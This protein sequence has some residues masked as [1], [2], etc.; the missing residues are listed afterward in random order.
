MYK[1]LFKSALR[2]ILNKKFYTVINGVGLTLGLLTFF[3]VV[4]HVSYEKNYDKFHKKADNIYRLTSATK[5]RTAA[6]VPYRWG[7]QMKEDIAEIENVVSFQNITI[8][9]TVKKGSEIYA[10]HGFLGVDST[11]LDIFDYPVLQGNRNELLR[12]PD[13]MVITPQIAVK[14]FN[15]EN[16]IGKT[17]KVNLWGTDVT[18][19][20]EGIVDCPKNAHLQFKFLIPIDPVK[21]N[22]FAPTAFDS[23]STHFAHSYF[24]MKDGFNQQKVERD[25]KSFLVNHGGNQLADKYTPALQPLT[26]V[27]LKSHGIHFDFQPRG[28][29]QQ[30]Y[31]L[32]AVAVGILIMAI[33][34]FTNIGS[35]QSLSRLKE[36]SV[37]KILGSRKTDLFLQFILESTILVLFSTVIAI[38]L[39]FFFNT[40]LTNFAGVTFLSPESITLPNLLVVL[41]IG[42]LI[43][44]ISGIYPALLTSSF[45]PISILSSR[46]GGK[47]KSGRTGKILV[48]IQFSLAIVLLSA[49][50]IVYKQIQYMVDKDLGFNKEQIII[51]S[52]AREVASNPLKM[53]L[54]KNTI[55][56]FEDVLSATATSSFPGDHEGQW[57]ARY[58]P[59]GMTPDES[60]SL[61]SIYADHDFVKTYD[62]EIVNGRDFNKD[63]SSDSTVTLL[64]EAA[65]ELF[66]NSN[67]LWK[68][69]P[70]D[71]YLES[72]GVRSRVIGVL[73]DFHFQSL[74]QEMNPLVIQ[75]NP[76]NAFS[77]QIRLKAS[78]IAQGIQ[79]VESSWKKLFPEIPFGY[80]FLDQ[81]FAIHF[82]S[83]QKLGK[84]LQIFTFLSIV[85]AA[86][87]LFGLATF[88]VHQK[89][90]EISI[91]KLM[92]APENQLTLMLCWDFL[93]LIV[94]ANIIAIPLSY[95]L[96]HNWLQGFSFKENLSLS[97]FALSSGL[98][99]VI[100]TI[101]IWKQAY[102]TSTVN[103]IEILNKE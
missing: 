7:N 72:G 77:I 41:S 13:K 3:A 12:K 31:I 62:L 89:S 100:A 95:L 40:F 83:D 90:R 80:S 46:F 76:E 24:L 39:L 57:S 66:S 69:A 5:E 56:E 29:N 18:F 55:L 48:V 4:L 42:L 47:L 21:K 43:G 33:I 94:I 101:S 98:S 64:N 32:L 22:F 68:S 67:P 51:L 25:L 52:S 87:G 86:L 60:V 61:W 82:A 15:G 49:T 8:A 63:I 45:K 74:K 78:S 103:P 30:I 97:V 28:D 9:L 81:R 44:I 34:N 1:L 6:I 10:Q 84:A 59:E 91:R 88:L 79:I 93:K 26:D 53:E 75:I 20:I 85:I 54:F 71:R 96:M 35:A 11:F 99:V 36:T 92:G 17:L 27:Y 16:P 2:N 50:G 14:Y 19:E 23:W 38:L 65:V 102:K 58:I 37:R 73:K 70:L